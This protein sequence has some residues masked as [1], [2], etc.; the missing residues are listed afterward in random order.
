MREQLQQV[1]L[2]TAISIAH[3]LAIHGEEFISSA[4]DE[5]T[6]LKFLE[7]VLSILEDNEKFEECSIIHNYKTRLEKD[8]QDRK[9]SQ[10]Y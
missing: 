4:V 9:A 3:S 5:E 7:N 6:K 2:N 10:T 8:G 1:L